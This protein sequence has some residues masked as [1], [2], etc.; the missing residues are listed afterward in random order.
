MLQNQQ[1]S[2]FDNFVP[3]TKEEKLALEI[4]RSLND[5]G[6]FYHYVKLCQKY[7]EKLLLEILNEVL[8]VPSYQIRKSRGAL[9]T[10]LIK[11]R[12]N[13]NQA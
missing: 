13:E 10:F 11:K 12:N 3:R 4:A 1:D 7:P 2:S 5:Q 8:A 9:F 6:S